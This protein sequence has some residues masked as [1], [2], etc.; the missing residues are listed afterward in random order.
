MNLS[1]EGDFQ[2]CISVPLRF[3]AKIFCEWNITV[4][5]DLLISKLC[6]LSLKPLKFSLDCKIAKLKPSYKK[7]LKTDPK[8]Y[9]LVSLLLLV[10]KVIEKVIIKSKIY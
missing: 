2:I 4:V 1:I 10:S 9:Y 7:G 3:V 5:L 6:N 8:K